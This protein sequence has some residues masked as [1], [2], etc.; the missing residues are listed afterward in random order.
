MRDKAE[1]ERQRYKGSRMNQPSYVTVS[2]NMTDTQ[3]KDSVSRI[4]REK[5]RYFMEMQDGFW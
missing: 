2:Q 3:G 5:E 4:S 1:G